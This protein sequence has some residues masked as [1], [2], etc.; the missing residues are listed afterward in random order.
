MLIVSICDKI[1]EFELKY[2]LFV[3][4]YLIDEIH[5]EKSVLTTD[6]LIY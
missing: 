6:F 4:L 2:T 1:I 3:N 5:S